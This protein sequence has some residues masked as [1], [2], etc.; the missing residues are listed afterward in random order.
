[1]TD[2][3]HLDG[4]ELDFTEDVTAD[5]DEVLGLVLFADVAGDQ[6]AIDRREIELIEWAAAVDGDA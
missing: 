3:G 6:H 1:V 2:D 5:G 4:C